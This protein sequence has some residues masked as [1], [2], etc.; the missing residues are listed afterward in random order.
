M[1]RRQRREAPPVSFFDRLTKL[2]RRQPAPPVFPTFTGWT[3]RVIPMQTLHM[4]E[5][6]L[7]HGRR[8]VVPA[9]N[10]LSWARQGL[11]QLENVPPP[12][13]LNR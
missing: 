4:G 1:E 9:A 8:Y 7:H 12:I 5:H 13:S 3:M 6:V 2:F 11:V 10:A